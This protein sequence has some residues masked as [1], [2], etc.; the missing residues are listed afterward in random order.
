MSFCVK[1]YISLSFTGPIGR[2]DNHVACLEKK[3]IDGINLLL[4]WLSYQ[5]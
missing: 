3:E 5:R 1:I 4:D 2:G